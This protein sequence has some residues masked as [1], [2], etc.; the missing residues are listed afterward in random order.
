M[1]APHAAID[2]IDGHPHAALAPAMIP[3]QVEIADRGKPMSYTTKSKA[4]AVSLQRKPSQVLESATSHPLSSSL[5]VTS[6]SANR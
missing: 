4:L 5:T 3:G 2:L 1:N 6:Q